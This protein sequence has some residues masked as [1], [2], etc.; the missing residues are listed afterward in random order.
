VTPQVEYRWRG[1]LADQELVALTESHGGNSAPGWWDQ[2]RSHSLGWVSAHTADGAAVGFVNVAW[3]GCDHA[4]VLDTKVRPD[5]QHRGIGTELVR[6]AALHAKDAGCEWIH[7]D[8]DDSDRLASFYLNACGF[9][10]S[11]AGVIHLPEL[12]DLP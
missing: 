8:F 3:D 1:E 11:S 4:F 10:P 2:V 6:Q 5:Y 12:A 9:R 7:V